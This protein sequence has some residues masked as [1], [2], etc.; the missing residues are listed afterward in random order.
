MASRN[1]NY[2]CRNRDNQDEQLK[3]VMLS[4][5]SA[6]RSFPGSKFILVEY[7]PLPDKPRYKDI[8]PKM[9][10]VRIVTIGNGIAKVLLEDSQLPA[11]NFY[12]HLGKDY[13]INH[14]TTA[15]FIVINQETILPT[16]SRNQLVTSLQEGCI[17]LAYKC[18]VSY[19][20]I[21]QSVDEIIDLFEK[22]ETVPPVTEVGVWGN[23]D[24]LGMSK[25]LYYEIGGLKMA[26]QNWGI[27]NE[28]LLRAG[29]VN[30]NTLGSNGPH[31]FSRNYSFFCL[32]HETDGKNRPF[33][34]NTSDPWAHSA[35]PISPEIVES[36]DQYIEEVVEL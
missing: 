34:G 28:I 6:Q 4:I 35:K 24:F 30:M 16:K 22:D 9:E 13:G 23:G 32:D 1:D 33:V 15:H 11:M 17:A 12:E 3:K 31:K 10:D 36:L 14:C 8:L 29:L 20:L 25:D 27:D 5:R 18:K 21:D 26:H 2:S 7:S 19:D